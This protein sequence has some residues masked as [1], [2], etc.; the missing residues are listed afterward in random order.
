ML[1]AEPAASAR[2]ARR[3]PQ[4]PLPRLP[5]R[6]NTQGP[7]KRETLLPSANNAMANAPSKALPLSAATS[8]AEY[9]SPQ[10]MNAHIAPMASGAPWPQVAC[11]PRMRNQTR[12]AASSSHTGWRASR[13]RARPRIKIGRAHV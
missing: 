7:T 2:P 9:N 3:M 5:N 10:G 12:R 13:K 6:S 1:T 8:K 4:A 11:S